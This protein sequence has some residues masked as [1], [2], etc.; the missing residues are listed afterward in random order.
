MQVNAD[1]K[2]VRSEA[3]ENLLK[4]PGKSFFRYTNISVALVFAAL[5]MATWFIKLE[6]FIAVPIVPSLN[7]SNELSLVCYKAYL[8][9]QIA[10]RITIGK[11]Y[12]I[13][14][15]DQSSAITKHV[16]A[17]LVKATVEQTVDKNGYRSFLLYFDSQNSIEMKRGNE[18]TTNLQ[19]DAGSERLFMKLLHMVKI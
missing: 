1:N 8:K 19:I 6:L 7:H 13:V 15:V 18:L 14:Y 9:Q 2:T 4:R 5:M 10:D 17:K 11:Q 12:K 3:F 16:S